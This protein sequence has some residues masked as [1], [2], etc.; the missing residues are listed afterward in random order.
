[1]YAGLAMGVGSPSTGLVLTH[2]RVSSEF[3]TGID[4]VGKIVFSVTE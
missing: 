3:W 1:M 4:V 2:Q